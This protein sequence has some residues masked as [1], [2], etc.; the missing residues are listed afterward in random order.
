VTLLLITQGYN[1]YYK[2]IKD[3]PYGDI[4]PKYLKV[5]IPPKVIHIT[6]RRIG[7]ENHKPHFVHNANLENDC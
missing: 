5:G 1:N 6:K 7:F 3:L 4:F 2:H